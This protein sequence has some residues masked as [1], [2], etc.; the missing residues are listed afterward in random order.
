[1]YAFR[2]DPENS[3]KVVFM[4]ILTLIGLGAIVLIALSLVIEAI[5]AM[6]KLAVIGIAVLGLLYVASVLLG[7]S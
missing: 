6:L 4:P 3:G 7:P 1:M 2:E 5:P